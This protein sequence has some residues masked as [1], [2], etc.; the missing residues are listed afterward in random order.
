MKKNLLLLILMIFLMVMNG[1]L[2]YLV[3]KQPN[4]K[5]APN[6]TFIADKLNF[7]AEQRSHF[8]ELEEFHHRKMQRI[9][10]EAKQLKEAMF[11]T[12][13]DTN[14]SSILIDDLAKEIGE[15]SKERELEIYRHFTEIAEI[16]TIPQKEELKELV[17]G[18]LRPGPPRNGRP[19]HHG[20]P[21][22]RR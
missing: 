19:P 17:K 15:L 18:A 2:L 3:I 6:R 22:P 9:D 8:S 21:P 14:E 13:A 4:Q 11:S 16:C 5:P 10:E 12:I 20:P 1:V 7:T